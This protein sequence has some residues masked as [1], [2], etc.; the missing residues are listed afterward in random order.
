[1]PI[2]MLTLSTICFTG[3]FIICVYEYIE[4]NTIHIFTALLPIFAVILYAM[5]YSTF[6]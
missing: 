3:G 4:E 1:M 2:L 5:S 6:K